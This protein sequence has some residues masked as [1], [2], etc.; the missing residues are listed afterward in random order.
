MKDQ[1]PSPDFNSKDYERPNQK[2]VCGWLCEG[3]PCHNGP[4]GKGKCGA[5]AD[6]QPTLDK[7]DPNNPCYVCTRSAKMGG[8]CQEGPRPDGSCSH[9]PRRC[10]PQYS[11]RTKRGIFTKTVTACTIGILLLFLYGAYRWKFISPGELSLK[12]RSAAFQ[13][14]A[15]E[16]F[17]KDQ[18]CATC[19]AAA[20]GGPIVWMESA[21]VA[22]PAPHEF[23]KL[24]LNPHPST[25]RIDL[26]CQKCHPLH[27]F[28]E[29][30]VAWEYSCSRCHQEHRGTITMKQPDAQN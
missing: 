1:L 10:Q 8:P 17:G 23:Y 20:K 16:A 7:T 2:W 19:H 6:C 5:T 11:L 26:S 21:A 4:D 13:Q 22:D 18:E 9:P 15:R 29:P 27:D 12:H 24:L 28:H 25:T 14:K 3:K 30:N